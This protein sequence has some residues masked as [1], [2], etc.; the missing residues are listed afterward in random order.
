[1][2]NG[3]SSFHTS[4][5]AVLTAQHSSAPGC[6]TGTPGETRRPR[7][8][9]HPCCCREYTTTQLHSSISTCS[10]LHELPKAILL[11]LL[12][13]MQSGVKEEQRYLFPLLATYKCSLWYPH[14]IFKKHICMCGTS[15]VH[16]VLKKSC[17]YITVHSVWPRNRM[18][19]QEAQFSLL[20][21][22]QMGIE[23]GIAAPGSDTALLLGHSH[24]A[25]VN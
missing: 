4:C 13:T 25:E 8:A 15:P 2:P 17:K 10:E 7:S 12:S 11:P 24:L 1:M 14:K 21:P 5:P 20:N 9:L 19:S 3:D 22:R 23:M 6:T 18:R 16:S